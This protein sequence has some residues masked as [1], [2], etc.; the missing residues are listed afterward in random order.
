MKAFVVL[1]AYNE[2]ENV[3]TL[4]S[5]LRELAEDTYQLDLQVILVDDGSTDD[6]AGIARRCAGSL[7]LDV[8]R[9]ETNLGLAGTFLRGVTAAA[10][11][12]RPHDVVVC[13]D[14]DNSHVP[15]Q[16]LR[17]IREVQEGRDVVIASRYRSGSVVRGVPWSRRVLS[18][19]M[20]VLF[21]IVLPLVRPGLIAS[22]ILIAIESW[23][24]ILFALLLTSTPASRTWPVGMKLLIGEFQLP[25]G[26]LA[27]A[28]VLTL[29]PVVVGFA[30]AGKTM[31]SGLTAGGLKD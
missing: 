8:L 18:Y 3:A 29:I 21:R 15:G 28:T 1:P 10:T 30:F 26:Q 22:A 19:G 27:A 11:R 25:W 9:N 2:A 12:S 6:T 16:I 4:L 20:S 13:M 31:I 5:K 17:M 14:A 24:D 7:A 23:N